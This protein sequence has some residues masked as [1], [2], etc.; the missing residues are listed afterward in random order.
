M[1]GG[2]W[3]GSFIAIRGGG[4]HGHGCGGGVRCPGRRVLRR[5][6][7]SGASSCGCLASWTTKEC[8]SV[9]WL[10]VAWRL[11]AEEGSGR[12]WRVDELHGD[13]VE[14]AR[15]GAGGGE[16]LEFTREGWTGAST[17][18]LPT[19]GHGGAVCCAARRLAI[20]LLAD[21]G[22]SGDAWRQEKRGREGGLAEQRGRGE[23]DR[24]ATSRSGG[25]DGWVFDSGDQYADHARSGIDAYISAHCSKSS[26]VLIVVRQMQN[27]ATLPTRVF[28]NS[29]FVLWE[30]LKILYCSKLK[31]MFWKGK[32]KEFGLKCFS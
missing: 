12:P 6:C 8:A 3:G 23:D 9:E 5:W 7:S 4:R 32:K 24:T 29:K 22:V 14:A 20:A 28:Q 1:L 2:G 26:V 30:N 11:Q 15:H 27:A 17:L 18:V 31:W 25:T 13:G 19:R 10:G 16:L 21:G